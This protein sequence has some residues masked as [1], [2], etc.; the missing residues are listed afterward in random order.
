MA[1]YRPFIVIDAP[2]YYGREGR[3]YSSH[4]TLTA[5][6]KARSTADTVTVAHNEPERNNGAGYVRG[7]RFWADMAPKS[8]LDR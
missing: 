8:A 5:A 7:D 4:A 6:K 1:T 3:V 2:G